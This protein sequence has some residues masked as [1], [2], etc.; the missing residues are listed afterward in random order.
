MPRPP[1]KVNAQ[2]AQDI[3]QY[4]SKALY[5]KRIFEDDEKTSDKAG[6]AFLKVTSLPDEHKDFDAFKK[7]LQRWVDVY[8]PTKKWQRCLGT[9]RQIQSNQRHDVKS[10]KLNHGTYTLLKTYADLHNLSLS[11]AILNLVISAQEEKKTPQTET[12]IINIIPS[13]TPSKRTIELKVWFD[14]ENNSKFVRGK[15]KANRRVQSLLGW[16]EG[17]KFEGKDWE[18]VI[19]VRYE[20]DEE[21]DNT[22][23]EIHDEIALIADCHHC[24]VDINIS[25]VD[26]R[27]HWFI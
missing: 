24:Q 6:Q 17:K 11:D 2:N 12:N 19:K 9:L 27:R 13:P 14:I 15:T 23:E 22:V 18:Y 10:I 1:V 21:L 26:D 25:T 16:Y 20:D 4:F 5:E 7:S 3:Y 8:V